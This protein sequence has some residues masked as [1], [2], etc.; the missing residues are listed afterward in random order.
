MSRRRRLALVLA[1]LAG[2]VGVTASGGFS[3]VSADRSVEIGVVEDGAAY[4]GVD[5]TAGPSPTTT[6]VD[7][8]TNTSENASDTAANRDATV[9]V[10]VTNR[11]DEPLREVTVTANDTVR[12]VDSLGVGEATTITLDT[13]CETLQVDATTASVS[14]RVERSCG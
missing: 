6:G 4:L 10:T 5:V 9:S 8:A 11:F 2:L 1:V 13:E 14:V 7:A 3:S 12:T